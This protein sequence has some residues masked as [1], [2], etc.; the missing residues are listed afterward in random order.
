MAITIFQPL[1][2]SEVGQRQN[3][4][5][6]YLP[7]KPDTK[8]KLF[9]V[10]DGMGGLDKGEEA[11]RI[12][13]QSVETYFVENPTDKI[14][15]AYIQKA[16]ESAFMNLA[17][18][19]DENS[20]ISRMGST[21][22]LLHLSAN[23]A[24]IAHIGDSRVYHVRG[25]EILYRTKDHKQVLDMV[26]DGIITAEQAMTHP[27][28][29]RLSHSISVRTIVAEEETTQKVDKAVVHQITD[30][31]K[32]DY[33][34]LC[35]DGVLE[36]ITDDILTG[37]LAKEQANE[38]KINSLLAHCKDKTKDNYTA[39][40]VQVSGEEDKTYQSLVNEQP[41][42]AEVPVTEKKSSLF[43]RWFMW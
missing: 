14:T 36:Q 25:G 43:R 33:F 3:N 37:I 2:F 16:V 20:L 40:L 8:T 35:T 39:M 7:I 24:T 29:N 38:V 22:T 23:E 9:I 6:Y 32:N 26:E 17:D 34:F 21:L 15:D 13:A 12:T 31:Q 19:M 18:Y 11:S 10:C 27:W 1:F 42:N 5:D 4:E 28:R 30:L 41:E